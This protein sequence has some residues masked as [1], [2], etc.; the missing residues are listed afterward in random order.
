ML[1]PII[2]DFSEENIGQYICALFNSNGGRLETNVP[3]ELDKTLSQIEDQIRSD[4]EPA[5]IFYTDFDLEKNIYSIEIPSVEDK[6][7]GYKGNIFVLTEDYKVEKP[8]IPKLR[9]MLRISSYRV[10]RWER[11]ENIDLALDDLDTEEIQKIATYCH[12]SAQNKDEVL[13]LLRDIDLYKNTKLT[14]ATDV[15]LSKRPSERLPQVNVRI[16]SFNQ[17]KSEATYR[18]IQN[19]SLPICKLIHECKRIILE[20]IQMPGYVFDEL[21]HRQ[22]IYSFPPVAIH[23]ALVNAVAHRDYSN[24]NGGILINIA[25]DYLKIWNSGSLPPEVAVSLKQ[26]KP[27]HVSIL[28]NPDIAKYLFLRQEMER[29]GKGSH[30][31]INECKK[32][33][34]NVEW[35]HDP[36]TTGV[37]I[38]FSLGESR[39]SIPEHLKKLI[40]VLD[41]EMTRQEIQNSLDIKDMEHCRNHYIKPALEHNLISMT[42]PD[43]PK[44]RNQ[45][46]YLSYYGKSLKKLK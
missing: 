10:E 45:K 41:G 17:D 19:L 13:S 27:N 26:H 33:G 7:Y 42:I 38:T 21:G 40:D 8:S 46:Y 20:Q 16:V 44:S 23:E 32:M 18:D 43:K 25:H 3:D 34:V 1:K 37:T 22:N 31:I 39:K 4:I 6:P 5:S 2:I 36:N 24:Y 35:E 15:C 9:E 12:Q 14:N 29:T 11:N 30:T 28:P